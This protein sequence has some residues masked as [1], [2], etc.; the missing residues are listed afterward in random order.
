MGT[1][2]LEKQQATFNLAGKP[3]AFYKIVLQ[4]EHN[5]SNYWIE[6]K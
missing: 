4:G 5:N 3:S 2:P 1:I 6:R